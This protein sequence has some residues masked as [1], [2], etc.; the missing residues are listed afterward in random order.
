[1]D[2]TDHV[3]EITVWNSALVRTLTGHTSTVLR[4]VISEDGR[5]ALSGSLDGTIRLWDLERWVCAYTAELPMGRSDPLKN[6]NFSR[7]DYWIGGLRDPE[8]V[9]RGA[10]GPV[11]IAASADLRYLV[12]A[13]LSGRTALVWDIQLNCLKARLVGHESVIFTAAMTK[14]GSWAATAGLDGTIRLWNLN[15]PPP[16]PSKKIRFSKK[17]GDQH[18]LFPARLLVGHTDIVNRVAFALLMYALGIWAFGI[19]HLVVRFDRDLLL[20]AN[21]FRYATG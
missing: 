21:D 6:Q 4:L 16:S 7:A 1:M 15:A 9:E 19:N 20:M 12:V 5:Y 3:V 8:A 17:T 13:V 18:D 10:L 2:P 14:D 11:A